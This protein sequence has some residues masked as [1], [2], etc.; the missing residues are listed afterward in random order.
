[1]SAPI[2]EAF[3]RI[4]PDASSF[5]QEAQA[6]VD[7][8]VKNVRPAANEQGLAAERAAELSQR[9]QATGISAEDAEEAIRKYGTTQAGL[10]QI[11]E[12][13]I[14]LEERR[15]RSMQA[16]TRA[17]VAAGIA[18]FGM[19]RVLGGAGAVAE[20]AFGEDSDFAQGLGDA[21]TALTSLA[22]LNVEG[23]IRA[24]GAE[25]ERTNKRIAESSKEATLAQLEQLR[26]GHELLNLS[27]ETQRA[28]EQQITVR[29]E[30]R[31]QIA[32][33]GTEEGTL[34][35]VRAAVAFAREL[36]RQFMAL[37]AAGADES[38]IAAALERKAQGWRT[39]RRENEA[40][41]SARAEALGRTEQTVQDRI[42]SAQLRG[43]DAEARAEQV[44][45]LNYYNARAADFTLSIEAARE[46]ARKANAQA[47]AIAAAD[48]EAADAKERQ[49]ASIELAGLQAAVQVAELT[50]TE[51][52]QD[53]AH[54]AVDRLLPAADAE[55]G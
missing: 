55:R 15:R 33:T 30:A 34:S 12:A 23:V 8:A 37:V 41:R 13:A 54:R 38:Q 20:M 19:G 32:V 9:L 39:V 22:T 24:I 40:V 31:F 10:V 47:D 53:A 1:M 46:Y 4:R 25:S 44:A 42:L 17:F 51:A 11:E 28:I 6:Q 21:G 29:R 36:D 2:G 26:A 7:Q 18:A 5:R 16:T 3:V 52:Q 27:R 48:R 45:L 43:A 14:A 35:R 50:G 49:T